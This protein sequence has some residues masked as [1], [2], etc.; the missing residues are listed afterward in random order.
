M[1]KLFLILPILFFL[2]SPIVHADNVW[3]MAES[4]SYGRKFGGMLGRGLVNL[5]TC[6]VDVIVSTV[7]GTK[8]GPPFIGTVT[9]LGRGIGCTTLRALSGALDLVT[10]WVPGFNGYP[11]CKS[12]ADCIS[13]G[14]KDEVVYQPPMMAQPG[15]QPPQPA[16]VQGQEPYAPPAR[17][18]EGPMKYVKK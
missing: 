9:G 7:D 1:K 15:Y 11:V 10:F 4:P 13:C 6:F 2:L 14:Q 17:R 3:T 12:Y 8:H 16:V 18:E 5:A